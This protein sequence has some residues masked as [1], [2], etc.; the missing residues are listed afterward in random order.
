[1]QDKN[2]DFVVAEHQTLLSNSSSG[3]VSNL[4]QEADSGQTSPKHSTMQAASGVVATL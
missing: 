2:K 1:L 4:F 3:F